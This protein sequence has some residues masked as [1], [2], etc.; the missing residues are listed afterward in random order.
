MTSLFNR[1]H[2]VV[3]ALTLTLLYGCAVQEINKMGVRAREDG[4]SAQRIMKSRSSLTHP[5]VSWT[6]KPWVNLDPIT[7]LIAVSDDKKVPLCPIIINRTNGISL[8]EVGQRITALCGMRVSITPDA[9]SALSSRTAGYAS[10]QPMSGK[11]P[12]PD[13]NGRVS[14]AKMADQQNMQSVSASADLGLLTGLKWNDDLNGLLDTVASRFA[15]SWRVEQGTVVFYSFDTRTFQLSLLNTK[16]D[17]SASIN[18]GSGTQLGSAGASSASGDINTAQKTAYDLSSN[19]YDDIRKTVE[20]MLTPKT[21]RYW[22]S[23]SSGSLTATDTQEVLNRVGRFVEYENKL[24][25][26]QIQLNIQI[27]SVTQ[28]HNEELGLDWD[29]VYKSLSNYG[30]NVKGSLN[31][32]SSG[33]GS[34]AFSIMDT[35]SGSARHFAGSNLIVKALSEQGDVSVVTSQSRVTTNFTPVPYQLSNQQGMVTSSGST[36]TANVGVT[37]TMTTTTLITGLFITA[38]PSIEEN[39]NVRL[40]FAFS[41]DSPPKI[42]SFFSADGNTRNDIANYSK[43][44]VTQ[45]FN[46][47]TVQTLMV[48]GADQL[49]NSADRQGV[50]SADFFA[51]GGGRKGT[52][53]RTTLVILITPILLG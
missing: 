37:S 30:V 16:I 31:N 26:R 53:K 36:A 46:M 15:L 21:G 43:E 49:T 32:A 13:D 12:E 2:C 7:S 52:N 8:P 29:L 45:K 23:S 25:N 27:M 17:S 38:V 3:L 48:T 1:N 9:L 11:L 22:L 51:L 20:N 5:T 44:A 19:L 34:T 28:T 6:D 47:R 39:G 10:T 33:V 18:S 24:L 4:D 14:L 42:E 40:Q 50:G 41:Y 35:A